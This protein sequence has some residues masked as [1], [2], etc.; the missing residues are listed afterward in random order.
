MSE[1]GAQGEFEI[2]HS[3]TFAPAPK[4]VIPDV[5]EDGFVIV[6]EPLM[7]VHVPVPFVG[8]FPAKVAVLP[9]IV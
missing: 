7:S 2:V 1:D 6:P 5:G 3:K 4:F 8:V 9:P